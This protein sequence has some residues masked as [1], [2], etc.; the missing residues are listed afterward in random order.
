MKLKTLWRKEKWLIMSHFY[1]CQNVSKS[2]LPK[3]RWKD[4]VF[5]N[6][7]DD[8]PPNM[9]DFK[10]YDAGALGYDRQRS[11]FGVEQILDSIVNLTGKNKSVRK[12]M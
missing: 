6:F 1:I 11:V 5:D 3:R 12:P 2:R 7:T 10:D 9:S 8:S 4:C